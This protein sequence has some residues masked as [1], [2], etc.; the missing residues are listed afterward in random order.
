[1]SNFMPVKK[2]FSVYQASDFYFAFSVMENGTAVD[3]SEATI[4]A[5][6]KTAQNSTATIFNFVIDKTDAETGKIVIE[7]KGTD[8]AAI[9]FDADSMQLYW[10]VLISTAEYSAVP[11]YGVLTLYHAVSNT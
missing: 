9:K 2:N 8:T 1:M 11:Y 7:A 3:L 10:D 6:A 5:K 4:I